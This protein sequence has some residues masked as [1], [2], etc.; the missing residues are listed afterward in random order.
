MKLS[1]FVFAT[2]LHGTHQD[3][4]AV[5]ALLKFCDQWKPDVKVFGGDLWDFAALRKGASEEEK[6]ESLLQDYAEG[7]QFIRDFRPQ[8]YLR[9]NHCERLWDLAEADKGVLSDCAIRMTQEIESEMKKIRCRMIP[10]ESEDGILKLGNLSMLHGYAHGVGAARKQAL[11]YGHS[12]FG[13]GHAIDS[14][15]VERHG[16]ATGRMVGSL[17]CRKMKYN[18]GQIGKLRQENGWGYGAYNERTGDY[19]A[20]QA[21]RV[22]DKFLCATELIEL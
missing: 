18:R 13:H 16:G 1:S 7:L 12:M 4:S 22:G 14:A 17:C 9:G 3:R 5:K 6:R 19:K 8:F 2:D 20:F 21:E 11:T 15:S 10:Y